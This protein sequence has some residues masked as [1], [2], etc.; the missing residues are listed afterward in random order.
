MA[1]RIRQYANAEIRAKVYE[2]RSIGKGVKVRCSVNQSRKN[3]DGTWDDKKLWLDVI[4]WNKDLVEYA[5]KLQKGDDLF[6]EGGRIEQSEFTDREGNQRSS[7]Q[8]VL[9]PFDCD[10]NRQLGTFGEKVAEAPKNG[11]KPEPF[12]FADDLSF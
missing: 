3:K 5:S 7:W 4:V 9:P 10:L 12:E 11:Y 1:D 6:V 8:V 2:A